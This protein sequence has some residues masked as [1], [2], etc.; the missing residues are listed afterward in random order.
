VSKLRSKLSK[1]T[2]A[3][4]AISVLVV[5][6]VGGALAFADDLPAVNDVRAV[7]SASA[8]GGSVQVTWTVSA[9][10]DRPDHWEVQ[11]KLTGAS[12]WT[13]A[14]DVPASSITATTAT[15]GTATVTGL[16]ND[17]GYV[18]QVREYDTPI[19]YSSVW[20]GSN[21]ATPTDGA[22]ATTTVQF[23]G[24]STESTAG[25][26]TSAPTYGF[27]PGEALYTAVY[28]TT[29][30]DATHGEMLAVS[31]VSNVGSIYASD[32]ASYLFTE[33]T[34]TLTYF[35]IDAASSANT[36]ATR[37]L[38]FRLDSTVP[39]ESITTGTAAP[40]GT[41]DWY[42]TNT[43]ITI[44]GSDPETMS[45]A[46]SDSGVTSISYRWGTDSF[47]TVSTD[48]AHV[49]VSALPLGSNV[50]EWKITDV[51]GNVS[52]VA[53]RTFK[54]DNVV[55]T[56]PTA[57]DAVAIAGDKVRLTW[58]AAVDV[59]SG[60]ETYTVEGSTSSTFSTSASVETTDSWVVTSSVLTTDVLCDSFTN[61]STVY[62]RVK[63]TDEAS[64]VGT[65]SPTANAASPDGTG[66]DVTLTPSAQT[67][68]TASSVTCTITAIDPGCGLDYFKYRYYLT[69]VTTPT[70]AWTTVSGGGA[71]ATTYT[72]AVVM[73]EGD[74]TLQVVSSDMLSNT[75]TETG[76]FKV[77]LTAPVTAWTVSPTGPKSV[78]ET[79]GVTT[80]VMFSFTD[81]AGAEATTTYWWDSGTAASTVGTTTV[82]TST[83]TTVTP[84]GP[85][86]YTL[87]YYSTDFAGNKEATQTA[88]FLVDLTQPMITFAPVEAATVWKTTSSVVTLTAAASDST[89][90]SSI[91]YQIDSDAGAWTAVTSSTAAVAYNLE[92]TH[93]VYAYADDVNGRDG[94]ISSW[95]YKLDTA[96]PVIGATT[97]A[98]VNNRY[99][100]VT[101]EITDL[102]S[103]VAT[104]VAWRSGENASIVSTFNA[105][106]GILTYTPSLPLVDGENLIQILARDVAGNPTLAASG[107]RF[108]TYTEGTTY[109]PI[110][111]ADRYATAIAASQEAFADGTADCVVI[112]T[113]LNWPDALGGA[114]LAQAKNGPIHRYATANLIAAATVAE[115]GSDF[116]GTAFVATG[117]NFPDALAASPLAAAGGMPLYLVQSSGISTV[118]VAAMQADG[119][120]TARDGSHSCKH[121]CDRATRWSQPLCDRRADRTVWRKRL[122]PRLGRS[123]Y[124]DW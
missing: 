67:T 20:T 33:G 62:F 68:W 56:A 44:N 85:G 5:V 19:S 73:P 30:V 6:L 27:Y 124:R 98:T 103:G 1:R 31:E 117:D 10:A 70:A 26:F 120:D 21:A 87:S 74:Y 40:N 41:N 39:T 119:V 15:V 14:A 63:A 11:Y 118:T 86:T 72:A 114:A 17:V 16:T 97:P 66:P 94:A 102:T 111:G 50:F 58:P 22:C 110:E 108:V 81:V 88:V 84:S 112:A 51:A 45:I 37:T 61:T 49:L 13:D 60:V 53:T 23:N 28:A 65:W 8:F 34:S 107:Y 106:T 55:P 113:G 95:I 91:Y 75:T 82:G 38:L 18:F 59:D 109:T 90:I 25:W 79:W 92:G 78:G 4:L 52:A 71:V 105:A 42:T 89:T 57:L 48:T 99:G 46:S 100:S 101:F 29:S 64:N 32:H 43:T 83:V 47:T 3:I 122:R 96:V 116:G 54:F 93:T 2:V 7:D 121:R 35:A 24:V 104:A 36:E 115:L 69:S 80:T 9:S 76:Q 77:D 12:T 123:G